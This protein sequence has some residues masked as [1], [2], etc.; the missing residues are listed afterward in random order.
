[1]IRV[2][3]LLLAVLVACDPPR[4]KDIITSDPPEGPPIGKRYADDF[5]R[6]ELGPDWWQT[7]GNYKI[8]DGALSAKGGK[9]HPLWLRRKLPKDAVIEFDAW[10]NSADGDIK[11][12]V[13]GD[14]RSFDPDGGAYRATGYVV[15]FGGWK[16][17]KSI[18][19]RQD[20]HGRDLA[21]DP[22]A[23]KV[24]RG[25][26]YHFRIERAGGVIDWQ[27]DGQPFVRYQD[28]RPLAG[29]NNAYFAFSNWATDVWFDNLV[30]TAR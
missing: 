16:N 18:I 8:V 17:T 10:S 26:R 23:R 5:Q 7:G 14:G 27:L 12:E 9:N 11:V 1:M 6:A 19:A 29:P 24:E 25:R 3:L 13:Y 28:A 15:V 21:V 22:S 4:R 30:I 20:E 2:T